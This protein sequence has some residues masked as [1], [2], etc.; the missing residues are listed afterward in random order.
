MSLA[1]NL[2][3][4][5]ALLATSI[6]ASLANR[7]A[8]WLQAVVMALNNAIW[9][10]IWYFFFQKY[11]NIRGWRLEGYITQIG[12]LAMGVGLSVVFFGGVRA[13]SASIARG[14]FDCHLILPK[15]SLTR[16]IWTKSSAAGWG[17]IGTGIFALVLAGHTALEKLP[18][19]AIGVFCCICAFTGVGLI[20]QSMTFWTGDTGITAIWLQDLT[21]SFGSYPERIYGNISRVLVYTVIPAAF[22]S[23]LPYQ[24]VEE[25]AVGVLAEAMVGSGILCALAWWTY[26]AGLR[27]YTSGNRFAAIV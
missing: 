26:S 5:H 16:V 10:A 13:L 14:N 9:V 20:A 12:I 1:G 19:V 23:L 17:D 27:R 21:I 24:A 4:A 3:Y 7:A 18:F 25:L 6:K 8:F 11:D 22:M 2:R 15:H